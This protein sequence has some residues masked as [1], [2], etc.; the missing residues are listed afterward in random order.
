MKRIVITVAILL[1]TI[2][3]QVKPG[4][5]VSFVQEA[6]TGVLTPNDP[7]TGWDGKAKVELHVMVHQEVGHIV[8][9]WFAD[10]WVYRDSFGNE[11]V[12]PFAGPYTVGQSRGPFIPDL[13]PNI[14]N[15][16][17]DR[18]P[19]LME[20][21]GIVGYHITALIFRGAFM[22]PEDETSFIIYNE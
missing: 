20:P 21:P 10:G 14:W 7:F 8:F 5:F 1:L 17:D 2:T 6:S 15:D 3:G 9:F 18:Y 22:F 16:E 12:V 13:G 4:E 11:T 19:T